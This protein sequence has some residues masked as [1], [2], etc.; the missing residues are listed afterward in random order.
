MKCTYEYFEFIEPFEKIAIGYVGRKC[1]SSLHIL[2]VF[3]RKYDEVQL[4]TRN[5]QIDTRFWLLNKAFSRFQLK[6]QPQT[7]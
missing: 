5:V 1:N 3:K 7:V 2:L 4:K 6:W